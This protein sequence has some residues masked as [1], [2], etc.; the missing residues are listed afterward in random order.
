MDN[1]LIPIS[2]IGEVAL[3]EPIYMTF[4]EATIGVRRNISYI[5]ILDMVQ[6]VVNFAITDQPILDGAL[7]QMLKDFAI[8]KFY[9][10]LDITIGKDTA[11]VETIYDE[12]D[13]LMSYGVIDEIKTK[14]SA[15]QLKFFNVTVDETLNSVM[16]YRNSARGILDSLASEAGGDANTIQSAMDLLGGE[17]ADRIAS[18]I[19]AANA[20]SGGKS[21]PGQ[22]EKIQGT[23]QAPETPAQ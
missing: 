6:F 14:V 12:Y 21:A 15:R 22:I 11:T 2:S 16:A 18:I 19:N 7:S 8:V 5:E 10:D 3:E 20:I 4:G 9:T 13:V 1:K 17:N 23:A